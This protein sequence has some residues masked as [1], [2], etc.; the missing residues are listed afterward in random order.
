[1]KKLLLAIGAAVG[2]VFGSRAGRRPY[3]QIKSKVKG[4]TGRSSVHDVASSTKNAMHRA[5]DAATSTIGQKVD[6]A[7]HHV[8]DAVDK[9]GDKVTEVLGSE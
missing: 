9:S 6:E 1:M 8:R 7:A 3:E 4:L 2:F 5:S